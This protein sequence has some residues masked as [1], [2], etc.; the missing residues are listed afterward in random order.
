VE[1][2]GSTNGTSVNGEEMASGQRLLLGPA[3][4][5]TVGDSVFAVEER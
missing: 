2:L 5:L 3:D 1:D 4:R